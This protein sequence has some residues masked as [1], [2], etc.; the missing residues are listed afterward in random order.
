MVPVV[1]KVYPDDM[2]TILPAAGN[3]GKA[4]ASNA[5]VAR[6]FHPLTRRFP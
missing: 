5:G 3:L 2:P 1:E 4:Q 6:V